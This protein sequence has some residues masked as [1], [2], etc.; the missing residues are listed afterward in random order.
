M[1]TR[2][3]AQQL[4]GGNGWRIVDEE[5][6]IAQLTVAI[7]LEPTRRAAFCSGC[8]ELKRRA[9]DT[10]RRERKWRHL[11]TWNWRTVVIAPLRRVRCRRCGVRVEQVPWA[12]TGARFTV[13]ME[14]EI[15]KRARD[16]PI[17]GVCRQLG[18]QWKT[19]MR[20]ITRHV[21]ESAA[22]RFGRRLRRI[23][24][25]EVSYGR[26]QSKYLTIV[27]D[28]D[29]G[30]VVWIGKGR[31][32]ETLEQ[33][34]VQLGRRRARRLVCVTMD[35]AQGYIA[36]VE[37]HAPQADIIFDRFHIERHLTN[38]VNEVRKQEFFRR[39]PRL[40]KVIRGKKWLLLRKR[41]R[42]HWRHRAPLDALL[43]LNRRLASAYILKEQF[44]HLWTYRTPE[45]MAAFLF[46]WRKL[47]RWQRLDPLSR[48]WDMLHDHLLGV[49]AWA[50]HRLTNAALEGNNARVRGLSQRARGYRNADHLMVML[51]HCGWHQPFAVG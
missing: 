46:E 37:K 44:D 51:Y 25:D 45:G 23:G 11:D 28:H 24:V 22:R 43:Q 14:A 10:K 34:F 33:F 6:D 49:V 12:R 40:R 26:G 3:L 9:L 47:L 31:E 18:L 21:E 27:W 41:R 38:A 2:I 50:K 4:Y 5:V 48:F 1:L 7:R 39:G 8:G 42:V 36:A 20:L 19:V 29:L 16:A 15:L 17:Q 13:Q 30:Q 32:R 35:M